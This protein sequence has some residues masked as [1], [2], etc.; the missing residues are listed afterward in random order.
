MNMPVL[1]WCVVNEGLGLIFRE[2]VGLELINGGYSRPAV[3]CG[4][5]CGGTFNL[6]VRVWY[7]HGSWRSFSHCHRGYMQGAAL[8]KQPE[9]EVQ[10][11]LHCGAWEQGPAGSHLIEY[12]AHPPE[13]KTQTGLIRSQVDAWPKLRITV[14]ILSLTFWIKTTNYRFTSQ[15]QSVQWVKYQMKRQEVIWE[16]SVAL[17]SLLKPPKVKFNN[18]LGHHQHVHIKASLLQ[19]GTPVCSWEYQ[20]NERS[21]K[22]LCPLH[23][24]H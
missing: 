16:S 2:L 10:L 13:R 8:T 7:Y 22:C 1:P 19:A 15:F 6:P 24:S 12:T 4:S 11:V 9:D 14:D 21:S 17:S 20:Q 18:S 3:F 5:A 23:K